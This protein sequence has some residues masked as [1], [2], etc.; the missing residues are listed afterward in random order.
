LFLHIAA[1][2]FDTY[3]PSLYSCMY[4]KVKK[5]FTL[6]VKRKMLKLK[7]GLRTLECAY[8]SFNKRPNPPTHD[9]AN[10]DFSTNR[11]ETDY[12]AACYIGKVFTFRTARGKGERYYGCIS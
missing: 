8:F 12:N 7:F 6:S 9:D 5:K 4:V 3:Y 10:A 2:A 1:A 11:D